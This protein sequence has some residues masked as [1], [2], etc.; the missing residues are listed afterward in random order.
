M[1]IPSVS[2]N[3]V[4]SFVAERQKEACTDLV[5]LCHDLRCMRTPDQ[6]HDTP[7]PTRIGT[8]FVTQVGATIAVDDVN[9]LCS[10]LLPSFL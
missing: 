10:E 6:E 7:T 8:A 3:V 1:Q 4:R 5:E 9:N 2:D